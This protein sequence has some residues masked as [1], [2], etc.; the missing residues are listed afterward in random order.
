MKKIFIL[1]TILAI[2]T[3]SCGNKKAKNTKTT[4][5]QSNTKPRLKMRI[6]FYNGIVW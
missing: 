1:I 2:D 3:L 5:S 6:N 4:V